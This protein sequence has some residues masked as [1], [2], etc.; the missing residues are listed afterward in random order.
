M[1]LTTRSV[2]VVSSKAGRAARERVSGLGLVGAQIMMAAARVRDGGRVEPDERELILDAADQFEAIAGRMSYL[3]GRKGTMP[4]VPPFSTGATNS[5]VFGST[6]VA[7]DKMVAVYE[8][9]ASE[10][11][12]LANNKLK[13]DDA[14]RLYTRFRGYVE[15]SRKDAI[16]TWHRREQDESRRF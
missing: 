15:R 12:R 7:P 4:R 14:G 2:R 11:K 10:L 13:A 6:R 16:A 9:L 5:I 3:A 1:T 8:R